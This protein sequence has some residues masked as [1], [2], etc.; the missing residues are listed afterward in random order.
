M[1][2]GTHK[3]YEA[4]ESSEILFRVLSM[5]LSV[6]TLILFLTRFEDVCF[7]GK[8]LRSTVVGC[9]NFCVRL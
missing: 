5:L 2:F 1:I 3:F 4:Y 7:N 8:K 6:R 9:R